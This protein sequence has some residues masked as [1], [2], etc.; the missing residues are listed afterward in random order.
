MIMKHITLLAPH[1]SYGQTV[2]IEAHLA[3]LAA[4]GRLVDARFEH[5]VD[6][7]LERLGETELLVST[8]GMPVMDETMLE[9][10]PRLEA[11]FYAAG[12]V[13]TMVTP[14]MYARG[15]VI[16]S[17]APAN[18]I[19]VAEY[20]VAVMLLAN[21]R[22]WQA[23]RHDP[24]TAFDRRSVIGNY[25]RT[26]GIIAASMVGREVIR[27]LQAYDFSL[28]LYDPYVTPEEAAMLGVTRVELDELL[29]QSDIVS[30][31]A[32]NLPHLRHMLGAP[33]FALMHDGSTF[34]NTARGALVD[35]DALLRELATSRLFAVLDV[36]DPEPSPPG[37][38]FYSLPNVIYTPHIAGAVGPECARLADF[39]L[40]E[41]QRYLDGKPLR[42]SVSEAALARLA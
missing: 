28:L 8:W 26:I 2:F 36:T 30:L 10:M 37:H 7:V 5:S 17:A 27:L 15:V 19:P 33:Q 22:F 31:H 42:N 39:A 16:S 20:T 6:E 14:A 34:I 41:L 25:R 4:M 35:E 24:D 21:K 23:M 1:N 32:P 11:I 12:S 18:A 9:R 38:P 3:R 29:A 13:K 40:D